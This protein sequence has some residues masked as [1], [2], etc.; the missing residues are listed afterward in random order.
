MI[1]YMLDTNICIYVIKKRPIDALQKFNEHAGHICISSITLAE[2]IHGAEKSSYVE[3]NMSHVEDFI[4]RLE[5]LEYGNKAALHY[6]QIR[7]NLEKKGQIIGINDLHIAAHARSEGLIL[8]S[9]NLREFER[10]EALQTD[11]WI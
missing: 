7:A 5:V 11:N 2:L 3:K 4:S 8:V 1:K 6:G 9:N 10:V